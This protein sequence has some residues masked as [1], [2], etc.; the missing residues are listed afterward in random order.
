MRTAESLFSVPKEKFRNH[1]TEPDNSRFQFVSITSR[2]E[3]DVIL[4]R[5]VLR[6]DLS[7]SQCDALIYGPVKQRKT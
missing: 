1:F 5:I 4:K 7:G 2:I 6:E 3:T